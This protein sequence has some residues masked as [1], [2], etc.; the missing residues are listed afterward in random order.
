MSDIHVKSP[1]LKDRELGTYR[2]VAKVTVNG[3][4]CCC[5]STIDIPGLT[6]ATICGNTDA[7]SLSGFEDASGL[8]LDSS[9][10][11]GLN[12]VLT[13]TL[14]GITSAEQVAGPLTG[15]ISGTAGSRIVT[16]TITSAAF[17][18][19]DTIT[20]AEIEF[21]LPVKGADF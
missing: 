7:F 11:A 16:Y 13:G 4:S 19:A 18:T 3:P 5:A 12:W 17:E 8:A 6:I 2:V 21:I 20:D 1:A 15:A 9:R 14:S 10:A